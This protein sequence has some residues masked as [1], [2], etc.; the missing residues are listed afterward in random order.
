MDKKVRIVCKP[1]ETD[2]ISPAS[3]NTYKIVVWQECATF[4][5]VIDCQKWITNQR[6]RGN[7]E[8]LAVFTRDL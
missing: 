4:Y 7:T 3:G 6:K 2:V 5:R 8:S 1:V